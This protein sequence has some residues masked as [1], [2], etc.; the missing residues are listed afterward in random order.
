MKCEMKKNKKRGRGKWEGGFFD[1]NYD[2]WC[3]LEV[4]TLNFGGEKRESGIS[5]IKIR[6]WE[7]LSKNA[8]SWGK[9]SQNAENWGK[10]SKKL[11]IKEIFEKML[12]IEKK[13][14]N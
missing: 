2:F 7:K 4:S 1:G 9:F 3:S 10:F 13:A 6:K 5:D 12:K 14:K 11:K 8:K